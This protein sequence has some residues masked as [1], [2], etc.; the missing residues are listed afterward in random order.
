MALTFAR[1][2]G[3]RRI[4]DGIPIARDGNIMIYYVDD[5][6]DILKEQHPE[7][8]ED[9]VLNLVDDVAD[10]LGISNIS[11]KNLIDIDNDIIANEIPTN[12][13]G[14]R[15][16]AKVKD[17][18]GAMEAKFYRAKNTLSVV[19]PQIEGQTSRIYIF[20]QS[21]SGKSTWASK[22]AL[23]YLAVNP[24]NRVFIMSR[25]EYDPAF[26]PVIPDLIRVK[27]DRNFVKENRKKDPLDFYSD[28]LVIFDDFSK[29]PDTTIVKAVDQLKNSLLELGRQYNTN[30]IS[31][32]HKG[33][34]GLKSAAELSEC[35]SLVCFPRQ[36]PRESMNVYKKYLLFGNEAMKRIFDDDG[37]RERWMYI[38]KP[39]II[40]TENYIKI[41]D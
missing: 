6:I 14:K 19:P 29:I 41:I 12:R 34:G 25:K 5:P 2:A 18:L 36:N 40:V 35:T 11:T 39:N 31:I 9:L 22:Y 20:G 8:A 15:I 16:V 30:I 24:G 17:E 38:L 26:D 37:M 1:I 3:N 10:K 27:L 23:E 7:D 13:Y 21:G 32:Q 33:L 28:S 4:N